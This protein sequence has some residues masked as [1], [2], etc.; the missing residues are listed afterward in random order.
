MTGKYDD[1]YR[2][3][4]EDYLKS[5]AQRE[6]DESELLSILEYHGLFDYYGLGK[7]RRL[8]KKPQGES[9]YYKL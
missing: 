2:K 4:K 3:K 6:S 8:R 1:Y 9:Y 7:L 5:L